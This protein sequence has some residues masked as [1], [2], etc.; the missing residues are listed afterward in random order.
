VSTDLTDQVGFIHSLHANTISLSSRQR[1]NSGYCMYMYDYYFEK[2]YADVGGHKHDW[3]HI[4]VWVPDDSSKKKYVCASQHGEWLCHPQEKV[5]WDGD[6]PK[7]CLS[8]SLQLR[9]RLTT[10]TW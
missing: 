1:C 10:G 9:N 5:R 8:P 7:V 2:D 6:H 3:E 4:I